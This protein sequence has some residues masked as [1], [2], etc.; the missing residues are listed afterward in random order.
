MPLYLFVKLYL[1]TGTTRPFDKQ[2]FS[3]N[4]K[5]QHDC[6]PLFDSLR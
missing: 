6:K 2:D 1:A 3:V 4:K 5:N